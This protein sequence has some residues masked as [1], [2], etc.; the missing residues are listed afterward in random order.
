MLLFPDY[1]D[2]D[3]L[4]EIT[5]PAKKKNEVLKKIAILVVSLGIF[6]GTGLFLFTFKELMVVI[7]V[8]IIHEAGHLI[9]MKLFKYSDVKMFFLPLVGAAVTGRGP[10]PYSSKKALVSIAGPL[11]G[12]FIG[13]FFVVLYVRMKERIYYDIASMFIFINAFN[14]LPLYPLDGGRFF[15]L[16][17][18]SRDYAAEVIFKAITSLLFI[19]IAISLKTWVLL[20]IPLFILLSL[21]RSYYVYKAT[22][23]VK[24]D[25]FHAG[26]ETLE[27]DEEIVG[28]IRS[29]LDGKALRGKRNLKNIAALV[30][31]IWQR[32]FNI[33]P[34]PG[35]MV[36]LLFLYVVCVC[37]TVAAI[38]GITASSDQGRVYLIKGKYDQAISEFNK[39][40]EINPKDSEAYKNRGTAYMNKGNLD[41][42]ISDYTKALEINPK[43]AE[44]YNIRGR[45][46]YFEGKYEKSWEDLNKAEGLGY[47]VPPEFYDDLRKALGGPK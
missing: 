1:S 37:F 27:L 16:I 21:K 35:K 4:L 20:L 36:S 45:V 34:S 42:A 11:P 18:F 10:T 46:Y 7:I 12:L 43:D 2:T 41:Q 17:L 14:I 32:L 3:V 22:K 33:S 19:M 44:V 13:L 8:L 26:I 38:V 39:T 9:T 28:R 15:D 24:T 40:L 25:L 23:G 47:K 5:N 30:D 29:R 6:A 31:A